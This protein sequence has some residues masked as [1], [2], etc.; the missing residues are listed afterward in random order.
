MDKQFGKFAVLMSRAIG[1]IW[2]VVLVVAAILLSGWYAGF[3]N[4]WA[5]HTGGAAGVMAL[6]SVIFLQRSQNHNDNATHLKL[7]EL[8]KAIDGARNDVREVEKGSEE[9]LKQVKK[10]MRAANDSV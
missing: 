4:D 10:D 8:V 7:D 6:L 1:S 3:T 2:A 9:D 5:I